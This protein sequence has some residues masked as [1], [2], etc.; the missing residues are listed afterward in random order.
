MKSIL[1]EHFTHQTAV[2]MI[3]LIVIVTAAGCTPK[4]TGTVDVP[5]GDDMATQIKKGTTIYTENVPAFVL[6]GTGAFT[7]DFSATVNVT[8]VDDTR[9]IRGEIT[10]PTNIVGQNPEHNVVILYLCQPLSAEA[11]KLSDGTVA[12]GGTGYPQ[13]ITG[14]SYD[15]VGA[16]QHPWQDYPYVYIPSAIEFKQTSGGK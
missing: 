3:L 6:K 4:V 1:G 12:Y 7:A 11:D 9:T 14:Q 2:G 15:V 16:L 10:S 13:I 8:S 5:V